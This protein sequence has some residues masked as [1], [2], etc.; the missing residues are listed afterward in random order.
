[1]GIIIQK[2]NWCSKYAYTVEFEPSATALELE[3]DGYVVASLGV[4]SGYVPYTAF[5]AKD[6]YMK[7]NPEVIKGFVAALKK[8]MEYVDSHT[9]EE[10]AEVIAPQ[11]PDTDE[12]TMATI[13]KRYADQDT[14]K[15][16]LVFEED[17]YQLLLDILDEAGQL[18]ERPAYETL[19][20][21]DY[22]K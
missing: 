1:M 18:T 11:F 21:T 14:W 7:E 22:V 2:K 9:P 5:S 16:D 13:I 17:A 12:E 10:I 4:D 20:T 15:L 19:V 6:S 3:G 8:G